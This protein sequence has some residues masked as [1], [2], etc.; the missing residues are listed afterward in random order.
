MFVPSTTVSNVRDVILGG[1][2]VLVVGSWV[3]GKTT[4]L[5]NVRMLLAGRAAEVDHSSNEIPP[6]DRVLFLD[7]VERLPPRAVRQVAVRIARR[8]PTIMSSS[9]LPAVPS[10]LHRSLL[11]S[12]SAIVRLGT[13]DTREAA[14]LTR[15]WGIDRT[16]GEL[17]DLHVQSGG[18]GR[19]L[20]A[21][22][23]SQ[24]AADTF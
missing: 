14:E 6:D 18:I 9:T 8:H 16:P 22:V 23:A 4:L 24:T 21:L 2:S 10:A 17:F 7:D 15:H 5:E 20:R 13:L 11:D 12:D 3:V 19:L 1:S